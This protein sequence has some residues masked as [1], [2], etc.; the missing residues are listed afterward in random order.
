MIVSIQC[1]HNKGLKKSNNNVDKIQ[2]PH[3]NNKLI[4][5]SSP[6]QLC[7][8]THP[9]PQFYLHTLRQTFP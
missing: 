3:L 4:S 2:K 5:I 9:L 6:Q 1:V 8:A 7:F